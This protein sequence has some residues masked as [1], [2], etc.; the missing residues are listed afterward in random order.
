MGYLMF[1]TL[2][3]PKSSLD[4]HLWLFL[5][6]GFQA[7]HVF[8][9]YIQKINALTACL[10]IIRPNGVTIINIVGAIVAIIVV[11]STTEAT[12]K[13]QHP[14]IYRIYGCH[15]WHLI[16]PK[17]VSWHWSQ[18]AYTA[19]LIALSNTPCISSIC[20]DFQLSLLD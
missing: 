15:G 11:S 1:D 8:H 9:V 2:M 16:V 19:Q 3:Y 12:E 20:C 10:L 18:K 13:K 6:V 17:K 14:I 4:G 7:R 5:T